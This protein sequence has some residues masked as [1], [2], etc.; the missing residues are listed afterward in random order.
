MD[1]PRHL[2]RNAGLFITAL[3]L[4][5]CL[6]VKD[7]RR[8]DSPPA[9]NRGFAFVRESHSDDRNKLHILDDKAEYYASMQLTRKGAASDP[10]V[11]PDGRAVA[12]VYSGENMQ[13]IKELRIVAT[14][15][16]GKTATL[17]VAGRQECSHCSDFRTPVFSPDGRFI[18]FAFRRNDEP[19][20]YDCALGRV[21]V[22]G[23][24]FKQI[25]PDS[26]RSYGSPSFFPDGKNLLASVGDSCGFFWL[27]HTGVAKIGL[28]GTIM[29]ITDTLGGRIANRVVIS[30]EGS[31]MAIEARFVDN[32]SLGESI[33]VASLNP[34]GPLKRVVLHP[35]EPG[36]QD[37]SPTWVTPDQVAF[38]SSAGGGWNIYRVNVD[39]DQA[40]SGSLLIPTAMEPSYYNG[41]GS[42]NSRVVS[43]LEPETPSNPKIEHG[44]GL[45]SASAGVA[46][47]QNGP[48]AVT[49][50]LM[51]RLGSIGLWDHLLIDM[52]MDF[53]FTAGTTTDISGFTSVE[54]KL[55][56]AFNYASGS[57]GCNFLLGAGIHAGAM[58][59]DFIFISSLDQ[60]YA[61]PRI[62]SGLLCSDGRMTLI[63]T[64]LIGVTNQLEDDVMLVEAGVLA[65]YFVGANMVAS[66]EGSYVRSSGGDDQ[67]KS[68]SAT[69]DALVSKRTW[70]GGYVR[71][72]ERTRM[73]G[74][75]ATKNGYIYVGG[76]ISLDH[77][78]ED[79]LE[80]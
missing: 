25:T 48:T 54:A 68:W 32:E 74:L 53:K 20:A 39:S 52:G 1:T 73:V 75:N 51:W 9:F 7:S 24:N 63:V 58:D 60:L 29:P 49:T 34:V 41:S 11:S 33:F 55:D 14:D 76:V 3:G 12:Y 70:I 72:N 47:E 40:S 31:R 71:I 46:H 77:L 8:E 28:D 56:G 35:N 78:F 62:Q 67:S 30:P 45:M 17:L 19:Y 36:A 69:I 13:E 23:S 79:L 42:L 26:P 18:V 15:G 80:D 44:M 43:T 64:P 38:S 2:W 66:I 61:V 65:R 21:D 4:A 5:A 22:D 37:L 6:S 10:A 57:R 16:T 59:G 27:D 50:E